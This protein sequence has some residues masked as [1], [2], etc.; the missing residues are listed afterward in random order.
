MTEGPLW[1]L[2]ATYP[3]DVPHTPSQSA[4][5]ELAIV[6]RRTLVLGR[7]VGGGDS[8]EEGLHQAPGDVVPVADMR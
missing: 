5:I 8:G 1:Y 3:E 4:E 7:H 6:R 2:T